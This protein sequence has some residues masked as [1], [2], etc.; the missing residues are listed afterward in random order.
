MKLL[1]ERTLD[2]I[3]SLTRGVFRFHELWLRETTVAGSRWQRAHLRREIIP[4]VDARSVRS[5]ATGVLSLTT[6]HEGNMRATPAIRRSPVTV[7]LAFTWSGWTIMF[8]G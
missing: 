7:N 2:E 3:A 1:N 5:P 4:G 8:T 6:M